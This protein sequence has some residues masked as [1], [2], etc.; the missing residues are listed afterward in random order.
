MSEF[1][2]YILDA[3]SRVFAIHGEHDDVLSLYN[4]YGGGYT[5]VVTDEVF[6][7]GY[8]E[9]YEDE[10]GE[11]QTRN[12]PGD[13]VDP[14]RVHKRDT[15]AFEMAC[16][17]FREV[18]YGIRQLMGNPNFKG[19]FDEMGAFSMSPEAQT[20]TG[21]FLATSWMAADKLCTYEAAK[22]GLGQPA[23]W[24]KCWELAE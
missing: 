3:D 5:E 7:L 15:A 14:A 12:V 24:Y 4:T 18:V 2:K 13:L 9:D 10:H 16:V 6:R 11:M 17:K 19:G 22:L 1:Y 23:W 21:M 20:P 8:S